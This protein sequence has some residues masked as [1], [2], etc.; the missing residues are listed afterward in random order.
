MRSLASARLGQFAALAL[1]IT[2]G[3]CGGG[4]DDGGGGGGIVVVP[5]T[6][7]LFVSNNGA[8]NFG[9][10]DQVDDAGLLLQSFATGNNQGIVIDLAGNA[11]QA[12]DVNAPADPGSIVFISAIGRRGDTAFDDSCDR[13]I[14]GAGTTMTGLV[15]PKGL[16][17]AHLGGFLIVADNGAGD[18]KVFASGAAGDVPP[19]ATVPLPA[20]PWDVVFDE[21]VDRL[22]VALTDGTCA[23]FDPFLADGFGQSGPVRRFFADDGNNVQTSVNFHGIDYD[24]VDDMVILSDVG[25]TNLV[26]DGTLFLFTL[27][28]QQ[29]GRTVPSRMIEGPASMLGN[30]VDVTLTQGT[31]RVAEKANGVVV[32]FDNVAVG[33][34]GDLAPTLVV[35]RAGAE[36]LGPQVVSVPVP[37]DVTDI[38]DVAIPLLGIATT[39]NPGSGLPG[40]GLI[41]RLEADLSGLLGTFDAELELENIVF[42]VT[43]DAFITYD[44]GVNGGI[45]VINRLARSRD[46]D[47]VQADRDRLIIG[48]NTRLESP[49]G[50]DVSSVAGLVFVAE[51]GGNPAIVVFG[52]QASG[53]VAPTI[54]TDLSAFGRPWDLDYDAAAD[55]L[56]VAMT[57]GTVLVFDTY[58]ANSGINP[59]DRVITPTDGVA[60]ISVNLHGI[61][62]DP[63]RDVLILSDVG[64]PADA[65]D[66]Q[67]FVIDAAET[68]DGPVPVTTR[69]SGPATRLGNPVD[70]AFDGANVYVAEKSN[71]L[72]LR[73]DLILGSAGGDLAPDLSRAATAPES[74][75]VLP[76]TLSAT[77]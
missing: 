59:P 52:T 2:L 38:D 5:Q 71:D 21:T 55:R 58:L 22:F 16:D 46:G 15:A 66:G 1:V 13:R 37:A 32:E 42:D 61:V 63:T 19:L 73:F 20:A 31:A 67:L 64:S 3:G 39:S 43:G 4:D 36:S 60:Q 11:I 40:S 45:V 57:N 7:A 6:F 35:P 25:N 30:P 74:V 69:F 72:I 49:K 34:S 44:E 51:A 50:L 18:L 27:A 41:D 10:V 68:A 70:I 33:E 53:D 26:D 12:G 8:G 29:D 62:H 75:C 48:A 47:N 9:T 54:F 56:F 76:T 65:T 77:P 23:V 14:G 24:P 28:S 17:I